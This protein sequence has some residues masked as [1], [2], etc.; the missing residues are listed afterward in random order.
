M[1][2]FLPSV[3]KLQK[4]LESDFDKQLEL[5]K[6]GKSKQVAEKYM[7]LIAN[8]RNAEEASYYHQL[9]LGEAGKFGLNTLA[10]M[11]NESYGSKKD[12]ISEREKIKK[13]QGKM[14]SIYRTYAGSIM[15]DPFN[16]DQGLTTGKDYIE[17]WVKNQGG[18]DAPEAYLNADELESSIKANITTETTE[19]G[20]AQEGSQYIIQVKNSRKSQTGSAVTTNFTNYYYDKASRR[21]WYD[22]NKNK[23]FDEGDTIGDST[24][25]EVEKQI[26][27]IDQ[28][29]NTKFN[30]NMDSARLSE[31]RRGND[32]TA[33][34]ISESIKNREAAK[35]GDYSSAKLMSYATVYS[36]LGK[37]TDSAKQR[38]WEDEVKPISGK[39]LST[40]NKLMNWAKVKGDLNAFN[41]LKMLSQ[42]DQSKLDQTSDL[43]NSALVDAVPMLRGILSSVLSSQVNTFQKESLGFSAEEMI[44]IRELYGNI[45]NAD[46]IKFAYINDKPLTEISFANKDKDTP[47]GYLPYNYIGLANQKDE[48]GNP[49]IFNN[50]ETKPEDQTDTK[51]L[52]RR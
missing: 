42:K 15:K 29:E 27:K 8:A 28:L 9:A 50:V 41:A 30:Q 21:M 37:V 52:R 11:I 33:W 43:S 40:W 17:S 18:I 35:L 45:V 22:T 38:K 19:A 4:L 13:G 44:G 16:P 25:P 7:P 23:K 31:Q 6:M 14:E 1:A 36:S 51:N 12:Q 39:E 32:L 34:S 20:L 48:Q 46:K 47:N 5:M 10:P 24:N 3:D 49:I 26:A 2:G